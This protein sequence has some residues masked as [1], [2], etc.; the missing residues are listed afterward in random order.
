M[1]KLVEKDQEEFGKVTIDGR[2]FEIVWTT[3][4]SYHGE[5]ELLTRSKEIEVFYEEP[6]GDTGEG[7]LNLNAENLMDQLKDHWPT[8]E[9]IQKWVEDAL[10]DLIANEEL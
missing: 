10:N 7:R 3:E 4:V 6:W 1:K 2:E 8:E 5:E 9:E